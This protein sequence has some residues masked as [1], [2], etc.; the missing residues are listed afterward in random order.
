MH[1]SIRRLVAPLFLAL[2]S[3]ASLPAASITASINYTG[4]VIG[5][6]EV[7]FSSAANVELQEITFTLPATFFFDTQS[8]GFGYAGSQDFQEWLTYSG[9]ATVTG[10]TP[11]TKASRDGASSLT[12]AFS[13]FTPS[14]STYKFL[15][16]VDGTA[17]LI[18]L[19]TCTGNVFQLAAC[20]LRNAPKRATNLAREG[21][22]SSVTGEQIAGMLVSFKFGGPGWN[23][24]TLTTTLAGSGL[25]T[26]DGEFNG[27]IVP[28][29]GT[30][31]ML[32]AGLLALAAM[33]RR[34]KS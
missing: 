24:V 5:Y 1:Q 28:E 20:E 7:E 31:A 14:E 27:T 13:G 11:G 10:L 3:A 25:L 17:T 23:P 21:V 12:M 29:P 19:E 30:Y 33:R 18:P 22:A 16:D 32:G 4:G 26:G 2:V 8:G 34:R 6:W 15:L 9:D